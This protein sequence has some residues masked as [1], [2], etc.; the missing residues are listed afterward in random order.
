VAVDERAQPGGEHPGRRTGADSGHP[1]RTEVAV[2]KLQ[3]RLQEIPVVPDPAGDAP[4]GVGVLNLANVL[5]IFRIAL[6]PVFA[7]FLFVGDGHETA[8]R[9]AAWGAYATA[10]MTDRLD[11]Q[12]ARSRGLV[13]EFG[14]L[15][16]PIADKALV[17]CA[18]IGLSVLGD[19]WWWVTVV[20]L[21]REIGVTLLR[22]WVLRH[23]VIPASRGGKLKTLLLNIGIGLYVL[24]LSGALHVVASVILGIAVAVAL[25]T[26]VDYVGTALD[27]R[28]KAA[29]E[30]LGAA[31]A[32]DA[33]AV[34]GSAHAR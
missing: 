20:V 23:G 9:I 21:A 6:V 14:K 22:F 15:A 17:G 4:S 30:A 5:T 13:T 19:L 11:G 3:T 32:Q 34:S 25:I 31:A 10:A 16:D 12:I 29:R 26:A 2:E 27:M 7:V 18:L 1:T 28:R 8:W 24:P 33:P